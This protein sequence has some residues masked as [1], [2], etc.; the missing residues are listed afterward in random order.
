MRISYTALVVAGALSLISCTRENGAHREEPAAREAGREAYRATQDIKRG[1]KK[2]E[3]ELRNT[4]KELR[5]GWN[6]AKRENKTTPPK[7]DR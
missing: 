3:Q 5:Q 2:A 1:A 6:E 7:R 4:G